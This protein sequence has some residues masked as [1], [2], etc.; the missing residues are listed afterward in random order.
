MDNKI[1]FLDIVIFLTLLTLLF[2]VVFFDGF[3]TLTSTVVLLLGYV[4]AYG[5]F[6]KV[7]SLQKVLFILSICF[8]VFFT[9]LH[10][11]WL[12]NSYSPFVA[13][14]NWYLIWLI[15][16]EGNINDMLIENS[17]FGVVMFI[18]YL[19]FNL[20]ILFLSDGGFIFTNDQLITGIYIVGTVVFSGY[21][22]ID[23]GVLSLSI[24]I[25]LSIIFVV[26]MMCDKH[27]DSSECS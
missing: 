21:M 11:F 9:S 23:L 20:L 12:F 2:V 1:A 19:V 16:K 17:K 18:W 10:P 8:V 5:F 7:K 15:F 6:Y 24:S 3:F 4:L 14:L 13:I 22:G 27:V 25:I 26:S